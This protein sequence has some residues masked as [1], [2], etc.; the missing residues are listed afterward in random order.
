MR[1]LPE[2]KSAALGLATN[3][4]GWKTRRKLLVIESDDWGALRMPSRQA[5]GRLRAA[6]IRVDRSR[7][8]SLDCLENREDF[9]SLMNVIDSHRDASGR[10][11]T[12]TFNTVMGN[13]DFESIERDGFEQFHHQHLFDSYRHYHGEELQP[14]WFEA[15]ARRLIQP[16]FHAREHLNVPLWMHDLKSGHAE[17]RLAFSESFY[18]LTTQTASERQ[19]NYLAAFW[20]ESTS[21]LE[22]TRDR[23]QDGLR[24]FHETFGFHSKTFI[25]CN[26]ILPEEAEPLLERAGVHLLQG[27]RGQFVPSAEGSSG[28]IRR[29]FTGQRTKTGLLRSVRNVM[30]EPFESDSIDWVNAALR[31]IS[32]SFAL[33]RPAII[34]SHRV[35]Y[36]GGLSRSHRD[37]SLR[38]L[39]TLLYRVRS[40]WPQVEFISSD[41]L[42]DEMMSN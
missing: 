38:M 7:Y 15:M 18:G 21:E 40:R 25:A 39:D 30:F 23:L 1:T 29:T 37:R 22:S 8:D 24:M 33:N 11:A 14:E 12:F 2:L 9:Q 34:S 4:W 31:Q 26:Y 35:N 13:P 27:Q 3:L 17:A 36:T 41:Q 42:L 10:P 32:Q 6:G 20:T 16:Q 5:W 28:R 19:V